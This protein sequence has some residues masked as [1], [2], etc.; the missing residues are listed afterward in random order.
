MLVDFGTKV[1][2]Q[3]AKLVRTILNLLVGSDFFSRPFSQNK[4]LVKP[5][6]MNLSHLSNPLKTGFS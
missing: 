3:F 4:A 5:N 6:L 1:E 2:M